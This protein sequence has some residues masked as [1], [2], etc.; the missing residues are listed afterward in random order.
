MRIP[1]HVRTVLF[2]LDGTLIDHEGAARAGVLAFAEQLGLPGSPGEVIRRWF[3]I[4]RRWYTRFERGQVTHAGQRVGR[5]RDFL[6]RP[7]MS[8][9]EAAT[10]FEVYALA[11]RRA[12]RPFPDAA[13]AL[14]R[15]LA[16]GRKV[17][18]FTNGATPMQSDKLADTGLDRPGVVM[19]AA[20]D[21]GAAKPQPAAYAAALGRMGV[22][23]AS[24][25]VLIGD[26]LGND[27]RG[28]RLAGMR[29]VYLDRGGQGE[30]ASL[31][32]V[33]F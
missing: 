1:A 33:G 17:G 20:T 31:D 23:D 15:A 22:Q 26:D 7:D 3:A 8:E 19:L 13:S 24:T 6:G 21:L 12:W 5:L 2:D 18:V 29:A 25:S 30:I 10:T 11:Y 16:S 9:D 4:E 28:A 14:D 27:V 32:E